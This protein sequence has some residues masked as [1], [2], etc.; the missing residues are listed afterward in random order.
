[1]TIID[2]YP[3]PNNHPYSQDDERFRQQ[4]RKKTG[5]EERFGE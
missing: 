4:K 5:D 3:F 2:E 1:M